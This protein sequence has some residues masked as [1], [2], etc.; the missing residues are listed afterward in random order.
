ML[1]IYWQRRLR[2]ME[3]V[4]KITVGIIIGAMMPHLTQTLPHGARPRS[5]ARATRSQS[6]ALSNICPKQPT[7]PI[8]TPSI[9][10]HKEAAQHA[11]QQRDAPTRMALHRLATHRL[12]VPQG[13]VALRNELGS[14]RELVPP[15]PLACRS[16]FSPLPH[17]A[18]PGG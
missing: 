12:A 15:C 14:F 2:V 5:G 4:V 1:D 16:L 13:L 6:K 11:S 18:L 7:Q 17:V 10:M 3:C 8:T 9:T